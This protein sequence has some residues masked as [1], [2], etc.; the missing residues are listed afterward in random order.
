MKTLPARPLL[1]LC[2]LLLATG[3]SKCN[4]KK[5]TTPDTAST[6]AQ[7]T[8]TT[9][10]FDPSGIRLDV[11][12]AMDK[13]LASCSFNEMNKP[14]CKDRT[15]VLAYRKVMNEHHL[16]GFPVI[17]DAFK[18]PD[19]QRRRI[20][21]YT[22]QSYG[23][24]MMQEATENPERLEDEHVRELMAALLNQHG[25]DLT[26]RDSIG[27]AVE[28]GTLKSFDDEVYGMIRSY[29]P[30]DRMAKIWI[31][32]EAIKH[33][34]RHARLRTFDFV[35]AEFETQEEVAI[36]QAALEAPLMMK[37]WTEQESEVI[38]EWAGSV[39]ATDDDIKWQ[40]AQAKLL[41]RCTDR[42]RWDAALVK[43]AKR[44]IDAGIYSRPF[45]D[46]M[47]MLCRERSLEERNA[48]QGTCASLRTLLMSVADNANLPDEERAYALSSLGLQWKDE[49]MEAYLTQKAESTSGIMNNHARAALKKITQRRA[50][51]A[52]NERAKT[53]PESERAK[54]A[55]DGYR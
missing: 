39:L 7:L 9:P 45:A 51:E 28:A 40:A 36:Q 22:F 10:P 2:V 32:A 46:Q 35:K 19:S 5:K 29:D 23:A 49:Q 42:D 33:L 52:A 12:N 26:P 44:R 20:A 4:D 38:C 8:A 24:A 6:S 30:K 16:W 3:C 18:S 37:E 17:V 25:L 1:L 34:M 41:M 27:V 11:R 47:G 55:Q 43:E 31:R 13:A 50:V 15:Q 48:A 14:E 21:A 53:I 54:A